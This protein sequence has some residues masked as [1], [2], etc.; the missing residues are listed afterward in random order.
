MAEPTTRFRLIP[1]NTLTTAI[2]TEAKRL[3]AIAG[4]SV[5]ST[6]VGNE[7]DFGTVDISGGAANSD[8]KTVLWDVTANGGNTTV[9][10]FRLW[11][12]EVGFSEAASKMRF[13]ALSGVDNATPSDTQNYA[14][15]AAVGTY[16]FAD[17]ATS[18][19]GAQNVYPTDEGASMDISGGAS[20][21]VLMWAMH[22][23]IAAGETT[24][25][26]KGTDVGYELQFSLRYS[27]S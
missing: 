3:A 15:D 26:Y 6:G 7:V 19:P 2:D 9:E 27:Y 17:M 4:Q 21:D 8:V 23:A 13:R 20:D 18:T 25:T 22:A 10:D 24:G 11:N 16:T 1:Q 14:A 12:N 5:V